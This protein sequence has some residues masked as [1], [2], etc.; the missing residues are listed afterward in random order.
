MGTEKK[1]REESYI[2]VTHLSHSSHAANYYATKT[3]M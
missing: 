2:M 3:G 1:E